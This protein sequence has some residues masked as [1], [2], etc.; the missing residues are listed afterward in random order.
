MG[1]WWKERKILMARGSMYKA[2]RGWG[3]FFFSG[4]EGNGLERFL[5]NSS[6]ESEL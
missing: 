3:E 2:R 1:S 6:W 4:M 5:E